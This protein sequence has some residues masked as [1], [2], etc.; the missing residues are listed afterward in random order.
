[1]SNRSASYK[2][3]EWVTNIKPKINKMND[4]VLV[5]GAWRFVD[6]NFEANWLELA[7]KA[8]RKVRKADP[9]FAKLS[10]RI[11]DPARDIVAA[12]VSAAKKIMKN[13]LASKY[14]VFIAVWDNA[15]FVLASVGGEIWIMSEC[16]LNAVL[17]AS[18]AKLIYNL[19]TL[20]GKRVV[21][22]SGNGN[23]VNDGSIP[24]QEVGSC[25]VAAFARAM[26]VAREGPEVG[27]VG[28]IPTDYAVLAQRLI[29]PPQ[30]AE[31]P[32]RV[33]GNDRIMKPIKD[34]ESVL[35][36][37]QQKRM[38]AVV[39]KAVDSDALHTCMKY[40]TAI[41]TPHQQRVI[42]FLMHSKQRGMVLF[43]T[44]GSGKTITAI[45]AARCLL[46]PGM[47]IVV[48]TPASVRKQFEREFDKLEIPDTK[49]RA[50]VVTHEGLASN[51]PRLVDEKTILII[52]EAHNFKS[53]VRIRTSAVIKA[54][55]KAYK[56]LLL[57][58]TPITNGAEDM[59]PMLAMIDGETDKKEIK[60]IA[61]RLKKSDNLAS[62]FKCKF[63]FFQTPM[64]VK[65]FPS[66]VEHYVTF[67]MDDV[68]Y[69]KYVQVQNAS[70]PKDTTDDMLAD[71][72]SE[73]VEAF[74][75]G[76]RRAANKMG[77]VKSPKIQYAIDRTLAD[78]R[79]GKKVMIY[80]GFKSNGVH[81][82]KNALEQAGVPVVFIDGSQPLKKRNDDVQKYNNGDIKV[83]LITLA[84]AEGL[85]LKG[86]RTVL[87]I[88]PWWNVAKIEQIVGRAVRFQS[89]T[90]LPK[91]ERHVEVLY[92][93]LVK[94]PVRSANDVVQLSAD[95]IL[96]RMGENKMKKIGEVYDVV[97][98]N[99]AERCKRPVRRGSV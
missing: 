49:A 40:K 64:D 69:E 36:P 53:A 70:I 48:A 1:M 61:K 86:T 54:A 95:E 13:E 59:A 45:A 4:P 51:Y 26:Y 52:D 18:Y 16:R 34:N 57:S 97:R 99:A 89:H 91:E 33:K 21:V 71:F 87:L 3:P 14:S 46:L 24:A 96:Y 74:M 11:L 12:N 56:V 38:S 27:A 60:A 88:D 8:M 6:S 43:H 29:A 76:I 17:G 5:N 90:M 37:H 20:A 67:P 84:G 85:D 35:H 73:T 93:V 31:L 2:E 15:T 9:A 44:V 94:P 75:N 42:D 55:A 83:L 63:S 79:N 23:D 92:L 19:E 25:T 72:D 77:E 10:P 50:T 80:S 62:L 41:L 68:Y 98:E 22:K 47:R 28:P 32:G 30:K 58:A 82:I 66:S 39:A 78:V 65:N 7:R 81:Y